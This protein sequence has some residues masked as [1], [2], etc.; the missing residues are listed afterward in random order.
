MRIPGRADQIDI[1]SLASYAEDSCRS[2]VHS[3][4]A[5]NNICLHIQLAVPVEPE[6]LVG[7]IHQYKSSVLIFI[8]GDLA[9]GAVLGR[10]VLMSIIRL[11]FSIDDCSHC[12][13]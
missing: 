4:S 2:I 12:C 10:L 1:S 9:D 11:E 3:S 8:I 13:S 5:G 7:N 6:L